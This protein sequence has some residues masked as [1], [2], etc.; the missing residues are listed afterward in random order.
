MSQHGVDL[1]GFKS[2]FLRSRRPYASSHFVQSY[3]VS[4]SM[5]G[6]ACA[7]VPSMSG[8]PRMRLWHLKC[9]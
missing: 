6:I 1:A 8:L 4:V 3:A 2:S 7:H 5:L 9:M